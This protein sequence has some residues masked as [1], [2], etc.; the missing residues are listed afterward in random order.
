MMRPSRQQEL[1]DEE[2][3]FDEDDDDEDEGTPA[4][5]GDD[6]TNAEIDY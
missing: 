1:L 2:R 5:A 4:H 3:Y 6:A